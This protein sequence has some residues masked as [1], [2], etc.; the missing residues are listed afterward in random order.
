[1]GNINN[2]S[3][4]SSSMVS[5]VSPPVLQRSTIPVKI[6]D[7]RFNINKLLTLQ[8]HKKDACEV[9]TNTLMYAEMRSNNQGI[10]KLVAGALK[11]DPDESEIR[12]CFESPV[13]AKLDGG[14]NSGMVVL[15]R[16]VKMAVQKAKTSGICIVGCSGYASA[17]GA[18]GVWAK[19]VADEGLI[20]IVM[21]QCNEYVA[22]HGSYEPIFGTNP[23][24]IGI[25]TQPRCQVLDMAT[26]ACAYYG[27]V[28]AKEEGKA[29]PDDVAYN[30]E[31]YPTTDPAEAI[32][33]AL[34]VFDRSFKG[35]HIALMIE[36]LAGSLT[37][38]AMDDK[39]KMENWGSLV[40]AIDPN[41]L[42]PGNNVEFQE[43]A[44]AMCNRVKNAKRLPGEEDKDLFL[45]GERGDIL[46]ARNL[47]EGTIQMSA[48]I[49]EA[50]LTLIEREEERIPPTP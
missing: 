14:R 6:E 40:I 35:S 2:G 29:I 12:V 43:R 44:M 20:G 17:T 42:G 41:V 11:P 15:N 7:L 50:L 33:G 45:P 18:L 39:A 36:L 49:Y 19:E 4:N 25:P 28:T 37:G 3:P 38:A 23:F 27:L 30:A 9:I 16:S 22:P 1:M 32:K 24:A 5:S 48:P 47:A 46:A 10:V 8:G 31:G 13:S 34:R 21:S 26:S